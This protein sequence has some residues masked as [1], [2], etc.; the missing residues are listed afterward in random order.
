[1]CF[2]GRCALRS[3]RWEP[4]YQKNLTRYSSRALRAD[5][6]S[7][8][9]QCVHVDRT[10][11]R[12]ALHHRLSCRPV[13]PRRSADTLIADLRSRLVV[14][15]ELP[16]DGLA[17]YPR[18]VGAEFGPSISYGMMIKQY[19]SGGLDDHRYALGRGVGFIKKTP[20]FGSPDLARTSTAHNERNSGTM[21]HKIGRT[22]RLVYCFSKRFENHVASSAWGYVWY[23]LG[24]IVKGLRVTPAGSRRRFRGRS[25]SAV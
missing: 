1:M 20:V 12:V 8:V 24:W 17:A 21:W 13:E 4:A 10:G 19:R 5:G 14:M 7:A 25:A 3:R 22:R 2:H 16:T 9:G 18:A 15:P 11:P 6:R 23:N